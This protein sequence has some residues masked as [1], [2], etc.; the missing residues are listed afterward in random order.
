MP[1]I[2]L[3]DKIQ[4]DSLTPDKVLNVMTY[5]SLR[6]SMIFGISWRLDKWPWRRDTS[7]VNH[8]ESLFLM[9]HC[10]A[11][12]VQGIFN[13][14]KIQDT[15]LTPDNVLNISI[16]WSHFCVIL[17]TSCKLFKMVQ[18]FS[19]PLSIYGAWLQ[20]SHSA[21]VQRHFYCTAYT[22]VYVRCTRKY[23]RKQVTYTSTIKSTKCVPKLI[24]YYYRTR[25]VNSAVWNDRGQKKHCDECEEKNE[26]QSWQWS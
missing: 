14:N 3:Y 9:L 24:Q 18:F 6:A 15:I 26:T 12:R 5:G 7:T 17:Y 16:Y 8:G 19:G 2:A 1:R 13:C 23:K 10:F 25:R 20:R 11:K 4:N 21:N 22:R